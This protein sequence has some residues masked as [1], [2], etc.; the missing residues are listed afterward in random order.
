MSTEF[1]GG[2]ASVAKAKNAV[3]E[4]QKAILH[5]LRERGFITTTSQLL[6]MSFRTI[7]RDSTCSRTKSIKNIAHMYPMTSKL[8]LV[9]WKNF[10]KEILDCIRHIPD[11]PLT[12]PFMPWSIY[13]CSTETQVQSVADYAL[14]P[15]IQNLIRILC[16]YF[17]HLNEGLFFVAEHWVGLCD[18]DRVWITKSSRQ[19]KMLVEFRTHWDFAVADIIAAY[20][21]QSARL[22]RGRLKSKGKVMCT[23]EQ[24]YTYMSINRH[25][26]GCLTTFNQTW[27]FK[28]EEDPANPDQSKILVSPAIASGSKEPYTLIAAWTYIIFTIEKSD[29]WMYPT[30]FSCQVSPRSLDPKSKYR[31]IKLD[32]LMHWQNVI[33]RCQAGGVAT[34]TFMDMENVVFK[35]IDISKR[36]EGLEQFNMEVEVYKR[37][38]ELQGI[39]IPRFI[40]Y[41]N[42]GGLL[43][44]IVLEHVGKIISREDAI[45]RTDEINEKLKLIRTK[46]IIHNDVR[47]R[48][49]LVDDQGKIKII[50]FG[51]ATEEGD[52][53]A[54]T[55]KL[56]SESDSG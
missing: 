33:A 36:D 7:Q 56:D 25:R 29:D 8:N 11:I 23:V 4:A 26:F 49:I 48:N 9:E 5:D 42:L 30:P 20:N 34:G 14:F 40:A 15:Q 46:G 52:E 39:C 12:D 19:A 17:D 55:F 27:F 38:E 18:P 35:T 13:E 45:A 41:G 51:F 22:E 47:R 16:P 43:Q 37:L 1:K 21:D 32:G 24:M 50:D 54:E 28:R 2:I 31:E 6:E 3:D 44:V 10:E 53:I